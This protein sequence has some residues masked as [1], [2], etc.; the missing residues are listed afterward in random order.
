MIHPLQKTFHGNLSATGAFHSEFYI[1]V[2]ILGGGTITAMYV[3]GSSSQ[4][5]TGNAYFGLKKNGT[6]LLTAGERVVLTAI[7]PEGEST[8][9]SE[10]VAFRDRLVPTLDAKDFASGSINGPIT[11]IVIVDDGVPAATASSGG[12]GMGEDGEPGESW[13]IPGPRGADGA[14]GATGATGPAG[15]QGFLRGEDGEPGETILVPGPIGATGAAGATGATLPGLPGPQGEDGIAG[16]EWMIPGPKGDT[17]ATGGGGGGI[18][19]TEVTGTSQSAAV[20]NGYI[21]NNA[22]LVTVTLP[23]TAAPG[24]IVDIQ[25]SG[26]GGWKLAQ[27]ASQ[28]VKDTA[29]GV[30]GTNETTAGTGGYLASTDRYDSV[31]VQCI[32]ANTTWVVK[33]S[34]GVIQKV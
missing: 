1:D 8:G 22:S 27:N 29:G 25:G 12:G 31:R 7:D 9:L 13:M 3:E 16:E 21:T 5:F 18:T 24:D 30:D 15:I 34:K 20:N 19:Y 4:T 26:A 14:A 33:D 32:I 23:A 11:V 2:D 10:S 28:E 17:G 6:D